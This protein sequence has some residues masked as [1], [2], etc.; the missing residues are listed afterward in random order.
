MLLPLLSRNWLRPKPL[1]V[2]KPNGI[3]IINFFFFGCW[4][5]YK[6]LRACVEIRE[7]NAVVYRDPT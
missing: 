7:E 6:G 2:D 5:G 3:I 4:I 1:H